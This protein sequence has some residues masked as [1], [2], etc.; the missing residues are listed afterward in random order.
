[1][2]QWMALFVFV[3]SYHL[4]ITGIFGAPGVHN[5]N[6][7]HNDPKRGAEDVRVRDPAGK[8][9]PMPDKVANRLLLEFYSHGISVLD[10][11]E[12]PPKQKIHRGP[13][14]HFEVPK[15]GE[16]ARIMWLSP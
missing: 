9:P 14:L 7:A 11:R 1:M 3:N 16:N 2:P 8:A 4:P 10:E 6:S 12:K 15:P 5:A 13:H